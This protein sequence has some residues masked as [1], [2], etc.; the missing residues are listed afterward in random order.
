MAR[1]VRQPV[2]LPRA[3]LILIETQ[4]AIPGEGVTVERYATLRRGVVYERHVAPSGVSQWFKVV[5]Q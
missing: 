5:R 3:K 1:E 2:A 4:T